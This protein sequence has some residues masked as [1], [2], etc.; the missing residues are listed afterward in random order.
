MS[1]PPSSRPTAPPVP[2][3][4]PKMANARARSFGSLNV[5]L[6]SARIDGA[7]SAPNAPCAA[8]AMTSMAK[9]LAAPPMAEATA[10][11]TS[12]ISSVV[13]RPNRSDS[14]PPSSS[15]L[16]KLSEYAGDDPLPV[17]GAEV[18]G[19][20]RAGQRDVHDRGVQ[21]DHQL[22]EQQDREDRPAAR[23]SMRGVV[24]DRRL[25]N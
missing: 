13:R 4:A 7:S 19:L 22:R 8:R 18:Q 21:H 23:G 3:T 25:I 9:P 12:P 11:P 1:T 24:G 2:A 17:G 5:V 16:P 15:R 6:S 10:K 20:L 14:L